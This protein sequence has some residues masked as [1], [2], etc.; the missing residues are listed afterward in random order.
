MPSGSLATQKASRPGS[1]RTSR[2]R[3]ETSMPAAWWGPPS[4]LAVVLMVVLLPFLMV[5][6]ALRIRACP[7]NEQRPRQPFGLHLF[8]GRARRPVLSRGLGEAIGPR[9]NRSVAPALAAL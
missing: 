7:T 4:G 8:R 2:C 3:L 5:G 6:P 9:R 1:R